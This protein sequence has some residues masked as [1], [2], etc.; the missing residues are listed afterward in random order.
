MLRLLALGVLVVAAACGASAGPPTK[1]ADLVGVITRST[2]GGKTILVEEIPTDPSRGGKASV[3][4][5]ADTR[6]W[7]TIDPS[8]AFRIEASRLTV[9]I[10]ARVWFDGPV[11]TS[12]PL[13]GKAAD[14]A[15]GPAAAMRLLQILS[16]GSTSVIVRVNGAEAARVPCNGGV[17]LD[18]STAGLPALPWNIEVVRES[19]GV[20][21]LDQSVSDLPRWLLVQQDLAG[22]SASPILGPFVPCR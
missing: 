1:T 11:A 17:A 10:T 22:V 15:I 9:G 13:Q 2:N 19:D 14:I 21:L 6:I 12:Y 5:D 20:R 8:K 3:T 7:D 4:I 16:K 18:P